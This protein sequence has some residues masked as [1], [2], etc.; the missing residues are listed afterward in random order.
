MMELLGLVPLA[1]FAFIAL[2]GAWLSGYNR[3]RDD[4]MAEWRRIRWT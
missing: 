3:G 4:F 1:I 2:R